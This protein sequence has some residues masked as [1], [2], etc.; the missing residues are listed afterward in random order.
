MCTGHEHFA[1]AFSVKRHAVT[2]SGVLGEWEGCGIVVLFG[3]G[4]PTHFIT[5][6]IG[7]YVIESDDALP[8]IPHNLI[9][10][11]LIS[12][13]LNLMMLYPCRNRLPPPLCT[14]LGTPA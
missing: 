3:K 13:L 1:I 4:F 10:P 8:N 2:F 7:L 9:M 5:E 11:Y 6:V 14:V 12:G